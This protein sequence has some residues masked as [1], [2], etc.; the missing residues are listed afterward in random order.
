MVKTRSANL[1]QYCDYWANHGKYT[2]GK[3]VANGCFT[4]RRVAM[5]K[6]ETSPHWSAYI[7]VHLFRLIMAVLIV[8]I[9]AVYMAACIATSVG[10][11]NK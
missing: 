11:G 4:I 1:R 10:K 8:G 5:I 3:V 2:Q 7:V 6:T 9:A